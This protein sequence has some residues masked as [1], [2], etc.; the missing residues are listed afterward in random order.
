[1]DKPLSRKM[2]KGYQWAPN[3]R[4]YPH[5]QWTSQRMLREMQIKAKMRYHFYPS[6]WGE[7]TKKSISEA[8][9][10]VRE[11]IRSCISGGNMK[12]DK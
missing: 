3:Q 10:N 12:S 5:G 1:M 8:D 4:E 7:K 11:K 2:D 6:H 9:K